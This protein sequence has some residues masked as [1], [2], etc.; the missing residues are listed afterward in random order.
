[1]EIND[2]DKAAFARLAN[3]LSPENL[4]CDG[5]IPASAARKRG[6]ALRREWGAL[7]RKVGRKV[8]EDEVW[9][10]IQGMPAGTPW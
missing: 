2:T 9:Q 8:Q 10:W 3:A 6:A 7:E 4:C 1:M 5:E